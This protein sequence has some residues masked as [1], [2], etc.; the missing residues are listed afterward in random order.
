MLVV[1]QAQHG[2]ATARANGGIP[3]VRREEGAATAIAI[4]P[5]RRH[6][7]TLAHQDVRMIHGG[8]GEQQP[9]IGGEQVTDAAERGLRITDAAEYAGTDH[10]VERAGRQPLFADI[11]IDI[12]QGMAHP[13]IGRETATRFGE[14]ER[15]LVGEHVIHIEAVEQRCDGRGGGAGACADFQH[16]ERAAT[17]PPRRDLAKQ[18]GERMVV[19]SR[20]G[21]ATVDGE[22]DIDLS[23]REQQFERIAFVVEQGIQTL[24]VHAQVVDHRPG[25]ADQRGLRLGTIPYVP[26]VTSGLGGAIAVLRLRMQPA[27]RRQALQP[28]ANKPAVAFMDAGVG[29]R[30]VHTGNSSVA[31]C[32]PTC[33]GIEHRGLRRVM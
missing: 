29:Q 6:H 28:Q 3:T 30:L 15:T 27:R 13:R 7:E 4:A 10:R 17:V 18:G 20:G 2:I 25:R 12:E 22:G 5:G 16:T 32:A 23:A 31:P 19:V 21:F 33:Q 11:P 8:F 14:E 1:R 9:A 24:G 26:D